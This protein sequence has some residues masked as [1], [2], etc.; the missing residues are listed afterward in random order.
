MS[1]RK[2]CQQWCLVPPFASI[3]WA[4]SMRQLA[5]S[6]RW[7]ELFCY[8]EFWCLYNAT[9]LSCYMTPYQPLAARTDDLNPILYYL[10]F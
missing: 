6:L 9:T 2:I 7:K 3:F 5:N 8:K 10:N 1:H 4:L